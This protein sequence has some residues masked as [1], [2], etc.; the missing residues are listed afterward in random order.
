[1]FLISLTVVEW[2]GTTLDSLTDAN[3]TTC[4]NF[5]SAELE[6]QLIALEVFDEYASLM[7]LSVTGRGLVC[8]ASEDNCNSSLSTL[9][10]QQGRTKD[11]CVDASPL[12]LGAS[13][14]YQSATTA[15]DGDMTTCSYRCWCPAKTLW[16]QKNCDKVVVILDA[17]SV[18]TPGG[19]IELCEITAIMI[20]GN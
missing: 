10:Y 9:V 15:T 18:E 13:L 5:T 14:C 16:G 20:N 3:Y 11:G 12:C 19:N 17:G 6:K 7:A 1:M 2:N 8:S 4:W